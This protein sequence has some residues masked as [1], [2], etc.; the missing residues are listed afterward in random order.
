[1]DFTL[2]IQKIKEPSTGNWSTTL[3]GGY[4]NIT[5]K[6]YDIK[7]YKEPDKI[8][9]ANGNETDKNANNGY[10]SGKGEITGLISPFTNPITNAPVSLSKI[11]SSFED[12]YGWDMMQTPDIYLSYIAGS[13]ASSIEKKYK[14]EYGVEI[15][16]RVLKVPEEK[17]PDPGP[18]EKKEVPVAAT[19]SGTTASSATASAATEAGATAS[20]PQ[21]YG[22]FVFG[23]SKERIFS[24]QQFGE[25]SIVTKGIQ[26]E[27]QVE[28]PMDEAIQ[29]LEEEELDEYSESGFMATEETI[30]QVTQGEVVADTEALNKLKGYDPENPDPALST[31]T[32]AKYPVSKNKDANIKA[33][34]KS[35]KELGITNKYALAAM[36]AIVS[37]ES[38]FVPT[39]EA[40]Y[41][42]TSA[43]NIKKIFAAAKNKTDDEID[44]IKKDAF[45]FFNLVYG[46]KYGNAADEGFKYRGRGFNQ[47]TFKGN[48]EAYAKKIGVDIVKDP[49]L[50]NTVEVAA[51]ALAAYFKKNINEAP[52]SMKEHYGFKDINS[53]A[54]LDDAVG[55]FYHANAGFGNS[56]SAIAAD[57]TGGRK[58]AFKNAGPL[59]NTYK[60]QIS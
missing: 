4:E 53:F 22:E 1:M 52:N 28:I 7:R 19:A 9:D 32:N 47:I 21:L 43:K 36:L 14:A 59:F 27:E 12:S 13:V 8:R 37:K 55:A 34:I 11:E 51:K 58:K 24:S 41:S 18:V 17:K 25:L 42:G 46:G 57:P 56:V 31:D 44:T 50:M 23:V 29:M 40:S 15:K 49:D 48:Y 35:A 38:S 30:F 26:K 3:S 60:D 20:G 54:N 6:V 33:I 45:K 10:F 39:S 2:K 16:L 5:G